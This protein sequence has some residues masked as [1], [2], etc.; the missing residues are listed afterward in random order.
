MLRVRPTLSTVGSLT[1]MLNLE[2]LQ[3]DIPTL[4][5]SE[6]TYQAAFAF[7]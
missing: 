6:A 1:A 3:R 4:A 5:A 7:C 2:K